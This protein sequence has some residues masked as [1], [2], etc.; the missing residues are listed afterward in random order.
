MSIPTEFDAIVVGS[1]ISGGFAAKELTELG[2]KTLV[3]ERGRDVKHGEYPTASMNA[4]EFD[5]RYR[6]PNK[7]KE[8]YTVQSTTSAFNEASRHWFAN[9]QDHPYTVAE[10]TNFAW[11]RGYH[12]GGRSIMW[13]RQC[14]R[15]S[16]LDFN[17]NLKEGIGIDWPIRYKDIAPW[18]DHVEEFVGISGRAEGLEH[19]PDSRFLPEMEMTCAEKVVK[20]GIEKNYSDRM[21][22]IGRTA[23]L[24]QPHKGRGQCMYRNRC[25]RGCPYGAAFSSVA[26]TLP[27]AYA[28]GNLTLR[29][30]SV[31]HSVIYDEKLDKATGVRVIDGQTGET[32]EFFAKIIFLCASALHSTQILM[33][34]KTSRFS[35]GLGNSSGYLGKNIM[36]HHFNLGAAGIIP[37]MEDQYT[38]GRRPNGI[39]IP[40]FRNVKTKHADFLRGYGYQG[41]GL[42]E[43]FA[44]KA[45]LPGFGAE[46]KSSLQEP[47][48]WRMNLVGFGECLPYDENYVELNEDVK[49]KY[50]LP[51]LKMHVQFRENELKMR[52]DIKIQA[53]E[54]LEAA[55]A[56]NVA[57]WEVNNIPGLGIHEMGGA[58]MGRSPK[59]SVL[60]GN[61]QLHDAPNVFVTDGACMTSA[62]CVNPS[63]TYMALTARAAHFAVAALKRGDLG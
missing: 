51:T 47:G 35:E 13:G 34:S 6:T 1:G 38:Y 11:I 42:R 39:Y 55:G 9:D 56:V 15:W 5:H 8:I 19:L 21:M 14:Y 12:V 23:N 18:Y 29:P 3:L 63:L 57:T 45:N 62:S 10:G 58:R 30:H 24:T 25:I 7:D 46:F 61:N 36:D 16:D 60:N 37:G 17:A 20:A 54:M 53:A 26:S 32:H 41:G 4:W 50:G 31:V 43:D 40:R 44:A 28:T 2:L 22:T 48:P 33:Q 49:D 27:A 52:E 59:N